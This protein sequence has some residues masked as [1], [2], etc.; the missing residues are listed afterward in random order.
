MRFWRHHEETSDP[1][2]LYLTEDRVERLAQELLERAY[3]LAADPASS[4]VGLTPPSDLR[5][6]LGARDVVAWRVQQESRRSA[7][8]RAYRLVDGLMPPDLRVPLGL[9]SADRCTPRR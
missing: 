9:G 3:E 7:D 5:V 1:D 4:Q 2:H 8:L 6:V